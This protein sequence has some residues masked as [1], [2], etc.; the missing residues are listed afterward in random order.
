MIKLSELE[1]AFM[2]NDYSSF[3]E[4]VT[5]IDKETGELLT[6]ELYELEKDPEKMEELEDPDRYLGIPSR[7]DLKLGITIVY[8]FVFGYIPEEFDYVR[9]IFSRSGAYR[10][11]K[12]FLARRGLLHK[13]Y[14]FE[15]KRIREALL[16]WCK[17]N[18]IEVEIDYPVAKKEQNKKSE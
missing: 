13:W 10:R 7:H 12:D 1:I 4:F 9:G 18:G 5:V 16:T 15:E 11:F 17:R 2:A 6:F 8:D 3:D 14:D